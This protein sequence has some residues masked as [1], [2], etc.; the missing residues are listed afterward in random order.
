MCLMSYE[1]DQGTT[2]LLQYPQHD[3]PTGAVYRTHDVVQLQVS[4]VE[5]SV[6]AYHLLCEYAP[7]L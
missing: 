7:C 1:F 3:A 5:Q 2:V 4:C 6:D